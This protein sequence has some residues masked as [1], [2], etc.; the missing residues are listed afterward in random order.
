MFVTNPVLLDPDPNP[1]SGEPQTPAFQVPQGYRLVPEDDLAQLNRLAEQGRGAQP[2]LQRF[3]EAGLDPHSLTDPMLQ[4]LSKSAGHQQFT[5]DVLLREVFEAPDLNPQAQ[6]GQNGQAV[7]QG[8]SREEV[9]R[10]LSEREQQMLSLFEARQLHSQGEAEQNRLRAELAKSLEIPDEIGDDDHRNWLLHRA[11]Q[12][13][14]VD[15]MGR[16]GQYDDD[17]PLKGHFRPLG[18]KNFDSIAERVKQATALFGAQSQIDQAKTVVDGSPPSSGGG[19]S[20]GDPEPTTNDD[21]DHPTSLRELKDRQ[22]AFIAQQ[23]EQGASDG[24]PTSAGVG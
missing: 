22:E 14:I 19:Q 3:S 2:L 20:P 16:T 1:Q 7:P 5:P 4:L 13:A 23:I 24:Q 6:P 8:L 12:G 9:E 15:E 10:M 18:Q 21:N 11:L 17:H